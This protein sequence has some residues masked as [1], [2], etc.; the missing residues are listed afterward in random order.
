MG[1]TIVN[2]FKIRFKKKKIKKIKIHLSFKIS[3][4]KI[5]Q[6]ILCIKNKLKSF[7]FVLFIYKLK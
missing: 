6:I 1:W 4:L 3:K 2:I 7:L 5:Y